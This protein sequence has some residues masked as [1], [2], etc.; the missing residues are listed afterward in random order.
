[1]SRKSPSGSVQPASTT[2][3][4]SQSS[5]RTR[6]AV[7]LAA[8]SVR[9]SSPRAKGTFEV[10]LVDRDGCCARRSQPHLD[11]RS[12]VVPPGDVVERVEVE[13]GAEL[14]VEHARARCG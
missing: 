13:V 6:S 2:N 7:N 12:A 5:S 9:I 4:H 8:I 3:P 10:E 1:M 14:A 11:P